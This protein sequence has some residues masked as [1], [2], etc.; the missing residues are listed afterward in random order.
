[1]SQSPFKF[2]EINYIPITKTNTLKTFNKNF[3]INLIQIMQIV[4]ILSFCI[5]F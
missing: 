2:S 3:G 5:F 1:M 4:G